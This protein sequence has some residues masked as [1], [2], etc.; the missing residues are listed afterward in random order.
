M[1]GGKDGVVSSGAS[2]SASSYAAAAEVTAATIEFAFALPRATIVALV[3]AGTNSV[4]QAQAAIEMTHII[5][6]EKARYQEHLTELRRQNQKNLEQY[7]NSIRE[8]I[9][10]L[11]NELIAMGIQPPALSGSVEDQLAQMMAFYNKHTAVKK[12]AQPKKIFVKLTQASD[13]RKTVQLIQSTADQIILSGTS[14]S[15]RAQKIKDRLRAMLEAGTPDK[16]EVELLYKEL[17]IILPSAKKEEARRESLQ[18]EYNRELARARALYAL[19][20]K[21]LI[22]PAFSK[23][24][25]FIRIRACVIALKFLV[26]FPNKFKFSIEE[27]CML[28]TS[29]NATSVYIPGSA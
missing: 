26:Y 2:T 20:N 24:P 4:V 19:Q 29:S 21:I 6:H 13:I 15:A 25:C 11:R 9:G 17:R 3:K 22:F 18:S 8:E 28:A 16:A 7:D 10:R 5:N 14:F 1:S 12:T 27:G 23:S